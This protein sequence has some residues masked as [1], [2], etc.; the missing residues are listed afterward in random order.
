MKRSAKLL[1]PLGVLGAAL[2]VTFAMVSSRTSVETARPPDPAP[3]VEAVALVPET[4]TLDVVAQGTVEP[5]TESEL[6]AEV[7]GRIVWVS[8]EL[9]TGGA[10]DEGDV[11]ARIDARDYQIALEGAR[12]ALL[13]AESALS[14]AEATLARQRSMR[15]RGIS[16]QARLDEALHAQANAAAGERE[17]KV[18]VERARLDLGRT[19][20][21]APFASRVR[22]KHVDLGQ[23]VNRG[24]PL[25]RLYSVDFAEVRLPILDADLAHLE[26]PAASG[27]SEPTGPEVELTARVAGREARWTGRLVRSEGV[28]DER[29]RMLHVVARVDDPFALTD[30]SREALPMGLFVDATIRG[31]AAEGVFEIPRSA[32]RRADTILL[33]D[34]EDRLRIRQAE[35]LRSVRGVSWIRA[36]LLPGERLVTSP[37]EIATEGMTVRVLDAVASPEGRPGREAGP[38]EA[39]E[40]LAAEEP[41]AR[42]AEPAGAHSS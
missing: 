26:I 18:A 35:V 21:R 34:P 11:I 38:S 41:A 28:R 29:T 8:P 39:E 33:V 42:T 17:A 3:V 13:R 2:L 24:Q 25:A 22:E 20:I 40:S 14:N 16:S 36:R 19:R 1:L 30:A 32:L 6:V 10:F 4:V 15:E 27:G 37:L 9:A 23:F 7:A 5:V 31:R 12:A